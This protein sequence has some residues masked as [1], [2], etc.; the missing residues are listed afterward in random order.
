M[1]LKNELLVISWPS[2]DPN[3]P[4]KHC[5][6]RVK[7]NKPWIEKIDIEGAILAHANSYEESAQIVL[8]LK[9]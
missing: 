5:V 8:N 2:N 1:D 7:D 6:I 3:Q 9:K 4:P